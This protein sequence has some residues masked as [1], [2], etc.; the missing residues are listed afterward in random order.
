MVQE[1]VGDVHMPLGGARLD[2][3]QE[4]AWPQGGW[5]EDEGLPCLAPPGRQRCSH[6]SAGAE[7]ERSGGVEEEDEENLPESEHGKMS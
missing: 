7:E 2:A 6:A 4:A 1:K 5:E 3:G